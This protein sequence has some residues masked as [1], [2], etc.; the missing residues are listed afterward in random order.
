MLLGRGRS[1]REHS[2][3]T[4]EGAGEAQEPCVVWQAGVPIAKRHRRIQECLLRGVMSLRLVLLG[5]DQGCGW[6]G[7]EASPRPNLVRSPEKGLLA[8][9]PSLP[10][11][12]VVGVGRGI[13]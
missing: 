3:P 1:H 6:S 4:L 7:E 12:G 2:R 11:S 9:L 10:V 5:L 8:R 13:L